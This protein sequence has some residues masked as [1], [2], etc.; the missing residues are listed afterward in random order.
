[1]RLPDLLSVC[2]QLGDKLAKA[3]VNARKA[4]NLGFT[5]G[6]KFDCT[7]VM[8]TY[9]V[10]LGATPP[11]CSRLLST[12]VCSQQAHLAWSCHRRQSD[13]ALLRT[14]SHVLTLTRHNP[15]I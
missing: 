15:A 9:R 14:G 1:M 8:V 4:L 10:R 2:L 13:A 6:D 11:G 5:A 12:A 7:H 3:W